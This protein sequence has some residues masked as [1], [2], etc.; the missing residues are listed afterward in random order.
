MF[1][2]KTLL[3]GMGIVVLMAAINVLLEG[4]RNILPGTIA[5][6]YLALILLVATLWHARMGLFATAVATVCLIYFLPPQHSIRVTGE[7]HWIEL[8]AFVFTALTASLLSHRIQSA[9]ANADR[10]R[11]EA[12]RLYSLI[13]RMLLMNNVED[14]LSS[15]PRNLNVSFQF[16][17]SVLYIAAG[18]RYYASEGAPQP[19]PAD[20]LRSAMER[21]ANR[22]TRADYTLVP[23]R[24]GHNSLGILVIYGKAPAQEMQDAIA[25][26]ITLSMNRVTAVE[27]M[28]RAEAAR[29]NK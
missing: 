12:E 3:R 22:S 9:A 28:A 5:L 4:H 10:R 29:G 26:L 25:S 23:L 8:T 16:D 27:Q 24:A 18:D 19:P 13:Q 21:P 20:E 6:I 2:I 15:T 14:L 11:N 7:R 1:S 17:S